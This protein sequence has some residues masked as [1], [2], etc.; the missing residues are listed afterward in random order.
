MNSEKYQNEFGVLSA[1]GVGVIAT[2]TREPFRTIEA[3]RDWAFAKD[4]P[5]GCWNVR[6][7]W[8][9]QG[10]TDD[11]EQVPPK[12]GTIDPYMA[13][14]MILDVPGSGRS[15]WEEGV[16]VMH[17]THHWLEKHPGL[18]ECIR[19]YVRDLP[20]I[21]NLRLVMI[22]PETFTMPDDLKHD[23]P[24]LDYSLPDAEERSEILSYIIESSVPED[25]DTPEPFDGRELET[26]VASSGGMTQMEA[27]TAF[28]KAIILQKPVWPKPE[29]DTFNRVVLEAK[30]EIV[31][32]SDVLEMMDAVP[33][34]QVGGLEVY[35]EWI[36]VCA[37]CFGPEARAFGVDA[38][39]GAVCIGPPGTGKSLVGKATGAALN[40]PVVRFDAS[41]I[42]AGIVGESEGRARGAI[43]M[44]EAMSP[45]VAFVD[46]IDKGLGGAHKGGG[47]SGVSQRVLGIILTAM[48]ESKAQ[49][50]WMA[51]ANRT[52][53]LPPELLRKGRFD[54]VF[55]ILT[56]NRVERE[57][58]LSI[59][60]AKRNQETPNDIEVAIVA[61]KGFVGAEIEAAV[62][63]AVKKAFVTD[64]EVS[65]DSIAE[66]LHHMRPLKDAFPEDFAAME[67]W[68]ELNARLSS[69][70]VEEKETVA[71]VRKRKRTRKINN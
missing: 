18:I 70:P 68:A 1:S 42:F 13:M 36:E 64:G 12:D 60:L 49:I 23:V 16:F 20:E 32:H 27:E 50:F 67:K 48:Q 58:I 15:R 52:D 24:T 62:K 56:P 71:P 5:F 11:P 63:E 47:D 33:M 54:E 30:T 45:C 28:S 37:R 9:K 6:D 41:R 46:E 66:E 57:A 53:G 10:P 69:L 2:R 44:I 38:P 4:L 25:E 17:A 40:M 21:R 59:H 22:F 3:L 51:S 7:G 61:S 35:K 19:H 26:L 65:G 31:K 34:D 29:F 43:K 39:K 14:Q 8:V 55:A